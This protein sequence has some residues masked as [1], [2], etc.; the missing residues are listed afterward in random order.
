MIDFDLL[1]EIV[2]EEQKTEITRNM[3]YLE[4][5]FNAADVDGDGVLTFD[6]FAE[7]VRRVEP[8]L[9]TQRASALFADCL[10]SSG[11]DAIKPSAFADC[12]IRN[13]LLKTKATGKPTSKLSFKESQKVLKELCQKISLEGLEEEDTTPSAVRSALLSFPR[14][15][16]LGDPSPQLQQVQPPSWGPSGR[17]GASQ[18]RGSSAR[19][20]RRARRSARRPCGCTLRRSPMHLHTCTSGA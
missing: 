20:Q 15:S 6:E 10:H 13:G 11:G 5:V 4:A 19:R 3:R 17:P 9:S 2:I 1:S 8:N 14:H 18:L 7:M 16:S 12:A